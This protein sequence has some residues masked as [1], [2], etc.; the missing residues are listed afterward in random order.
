MDPKTAQ[1]GP[2]VA[3]TLFTL[4]LRVLMEIEEQ[5]SFF[6][7]GPR[8]PTRDQMLPFNIMVFNDDYRCNGWILF[9]C[10]MVRRHSES[11]IPFSEMQNRC[12]PSCLIA[13][14]FYPLSCRN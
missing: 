12:D 13:F 7:S 8:P 9:C 4:L 6:K 5:G 3:E 1:L 10:K 2:G 11:Q 14:L